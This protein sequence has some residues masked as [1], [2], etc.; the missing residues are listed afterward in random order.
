MTEQSL[1]DKYINLYNAHWKASKLA[2]KDGF[3][4]TSEEHTQRASMYLDFIDDLMQ[5]NP[6]L[7]GSKLGVRIH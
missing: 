1:L 6:S 2:H 3:F 5:L 4:M 7:D